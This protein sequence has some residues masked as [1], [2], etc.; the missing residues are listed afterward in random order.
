[1]QGEAI[2]RGKLV[3]GQGITRSKV[4]WRAR[5]NNKKKKSCLEGKGQQEAN[6]VS[7]RARDNKKQ[8]RLAREQGTAIKEHKVSQRARGSNKKKRKS[9]HKIKKSKRAT[10]SQIGSCTLALVHE[11][12]G[13]PGTPNPGV[14]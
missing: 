9:K 1:M 13:R 6:K 7:Q 5:G 3:G 8:A 4:S 14:G 2:D 12:L 11:K 10:T